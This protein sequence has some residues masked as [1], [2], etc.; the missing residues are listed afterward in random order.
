MSGTNWFS[1]TIYASNAR[2][3]IKKINI[4]K[5]KQTLDITEVEDTPEN[6]YNCAN[7]QI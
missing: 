7:I 5:R 3:P 4:D 2:L 1:T 6:C